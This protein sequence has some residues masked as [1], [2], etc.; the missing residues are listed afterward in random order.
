MKKKNKLPISI[1]I[2]TLGHNH[3]IKCLN[4]IYLGSFLPSEVLIV[5]PKENY[6][7]NFNFKSFFPNLNL[8][9][10]LSKK[11]NQVF[12]R[13]MGFKKAKNIYVMQLD[14]DVELDKECLYDLYKFIKGRQDVAVAPRYSNKINL[15]SIYKKPKNFLNKFYHWLINSS[16][17][18]S[19]GNISLSG[20]NYSEENRLFGYKY[21][22]WLSGGAII[23]NKKNLILENYYP[24]NFYKSFCEDILHSLIL[25]K[26]KIKLIK[27]FG[28]KVSAESG[29]IVDNPNIIKIFRDLYSEFLIRRYIVEKFKF[30]KFRLNIYYLIYTIRILIRI[31]R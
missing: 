29:K 24:F 31:C 20:F 27:F 26:K 8:I 15:S 13:I 5:V 21:H 10:I 17:G 28:A 14:D 12:Q 11:K 9:I 6:L 2:P 23:H 18:Y 30:S 25:R 7:K 4:K 19:P 1:V 22:E 3:L 16:K